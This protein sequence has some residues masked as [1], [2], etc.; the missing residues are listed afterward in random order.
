MIGNS[1]GKEWFPVF[2]VEPGTSSIAPENCRLF[3][4]K[5]ETD[6]AVAGKFP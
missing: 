5:S 4:E 6:Q 1:W 3:A 2:P